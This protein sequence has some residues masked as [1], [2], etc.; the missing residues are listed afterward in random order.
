LTNTTYLKNAKEF[1]KKQGGKENNG[2]A[3]IPDLLLKIFE[4]DVRTRIE[5]Q[6]GGK[7]EDLGPWFR[8]E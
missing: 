8:L 5:T 6:D 3:V 1:A 7:R 4:K 2:R